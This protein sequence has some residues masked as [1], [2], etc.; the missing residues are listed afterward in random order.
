MSERIK[1]NIILS[2]MAVLILAMI[3]GTGYWIWTKFA[4]PREENKVSITNLTEESKTE[5]SK[6]KNNIQAESASSAD[7]EAAPPAAEEPAYSADKE[8]TIL[9]AEVNVKVLNGGAPPGS[10]AKIRDLL[11]TKGYTKI[12]AANANLSSY[13]GVNIYYRAEFKS[14]AEKIKEAL[15]VQYKVIEMKEGT[16]AKE[17]SGDVVVILGR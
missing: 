9:P 8:K 5:E 16:N 11:K 1:E 12:E 10:A 7:K 2:A 17:A 15:A 13:A 4:S 14:E 3:A 6:N